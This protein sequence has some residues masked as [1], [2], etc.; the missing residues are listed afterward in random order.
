ML[1]FALFFFISLHIKIYHK[2]D[3]Y[4]LTL[5][6]WNMK[7]IIFLFIVTLCCTSIHAQ[8]ITIEKSVDRIAGIKNPSVVANETVEGIALPQTQYIA[9]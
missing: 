7:R 6:I 3:T 8:N 2:N 5:S 4:N 1:I 9:T